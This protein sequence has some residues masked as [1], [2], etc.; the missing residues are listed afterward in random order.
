MR[1]ASLAVGIIGL[2]GIS[3]SLW[4]DEPSTLLLGGAEVSTG[5]SY[6]YFGHVAPLPESSLGNGFVRKLWIDWSRYRYDK[7]GS[8]YDVSAPGA[9]IALGYQRA[10]ENH[11]WAA[12][13]GLAYR[14]SNLTPDDPTST[15]RRSMLRPKFQLE[16]EQTLDQTF[17]VSASGSYLSGQ[18]AYWVRGR[19]LRNIWSD[20]QTG[21]EAVA[22]GDPN[23]HASQ[24]GIVLLGLK[25]GNA[26][27]VG[28][29][30]GAQQIGGLNSHA[31]FGIEL[32]GMY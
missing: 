6:T 2:F 27:D 11:W 26:V 3:A 22:Q 17:K 10:S 21:L 24:L 31:Y 28:L 12:Y 23:Y 5:A 4:A 1:V 16:G 25:V 19:I 8:T 15:V 7:G 29:K 9:E 13:A 14:H 30:V 18:Q 32:G 20:R